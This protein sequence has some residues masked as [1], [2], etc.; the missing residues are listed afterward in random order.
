MIFAC[1]LYLF[2]FFHL[3]FVQSVQKYWL[4]WFKAHPLFH[5]FFSKC[6]QIILIY[7]DSIYLQLS[8]TISN[9]LSHFP[10]NTLNEYFISLLQLIYSFLYYFLELAKVLLPFDMIFRVSSFTDQ[11]YAWNSTPKAIQCRL[12][13]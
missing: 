10:H 1:Y 11:S 4:I 3:I 7:F 8:I 13:V 12:A 2:L 9:R 6:W 5:D